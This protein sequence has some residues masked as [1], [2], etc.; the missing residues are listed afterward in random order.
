MCFG[1]Y[2]VGRTFLDKW[3]KTPVSEDSLTDSMVNGPKLC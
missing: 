2:A 3:L 1:N